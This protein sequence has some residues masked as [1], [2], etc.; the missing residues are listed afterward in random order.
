MG[1]KKEVQKDLGGILTKYL[2]ETK[3]KWSKR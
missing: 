1:L 2:N 3:M